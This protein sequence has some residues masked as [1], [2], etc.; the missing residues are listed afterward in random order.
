VYEGTERVEEHEPGPGRLVEPVATY[1]HDLGC[2]ITGGHVVRA[3]ALAGRYVYG[4]FCSGRI[5]SL[6]TK[7]AG[8]V[9]L[10]RPRVPQLT[11]I[12]GDAEGRLLLVSASGSV[13]RAR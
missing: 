7:D 13:L 5:F 3:G 6:R 9:R 1:G 11:S 12:G 4:D 2:S 10:E 8:D